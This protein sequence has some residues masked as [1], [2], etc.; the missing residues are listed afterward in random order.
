MLRYFRRGCKMKPCVICSNIIKFSEFSMFI[1][2]GFVCESCLLKLG[3]KDP[4]D[5]EKYKMLILEFLQISKD[6]YIS[7]LET[8]YL[9]KRGM[10]QFSITNKG[11][12]LFIDEENNKFFFNGLDDN[13]TNPIHNFDDL[14]G[15]EIIQ[16]EKSI[17]KGG[18]G[19]ALIGGLLFGGVGAIVGGVT[20]DRKTEEVVQ[21]I[22]IKLEL[23]DMS[24]P[25]EN[26]LYW[27]ASLPSFR[28]GKMTPLFLDA[29]KSHL[30]KD[31][32]LLEL[33]LRKVEKK[34]ELTDKSELN[35][36]KNTIKDRLE[37]LR[38]LFDSGLLNEDEYKNQRNKIISEL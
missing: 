29:L 22:Q 11:G 36:S 19:T 20:G 24:N 38:D 7:R 26:V 16:N 1:K 37:N 31:A 3:Y 12:R 33:V 30:E 8:A 25:I 2:E 9:L 23:D 28:G 17:S 10:E 15:Y 32:A 18:L 6:E 27:D 13:I 35:V 5:R 21:K 34:K 4:N 14:L